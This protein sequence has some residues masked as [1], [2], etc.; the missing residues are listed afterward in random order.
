MLGK[1]GCTCRCVGGGGG[2]V[3]RRRRRPAAQCGSLSSA[4]PPRG[5]QRGRQLTTVGHVAPGPDPVA[6]V[7]AAPHLRRHHGTGHPHRGSAGERRPCPRDIPRAT[8][9][10]VEP[11]TAAAG[12]PAAGSATGSRS[13]TRPLGGPRADR[14]AEPVAL[15]PRHHRMHHAG[16]LAITGN[17]ESGRARQARSSSG[18]PPAI[19]SNRSVGPT[20]TAGP[21]AGRAAQA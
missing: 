13:A 11:A 6:V 7:A 21:D 18:P 17:A 3:P 10:I 14:D 16:R 8:R 12:G 5:G 19:C 2:V 4:R 15:C 9:R 20:A 1:G